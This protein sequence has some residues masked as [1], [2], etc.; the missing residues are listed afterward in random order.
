[1]RKFALP[2][3]AGMLVLGFTLVLAGFLAPPASGEDPADKGKAKSPQDVLKLSFKRPAVRATLAQ[4]IADLSKLAEVKIVVDWQGLIETGVKPE[5]A[6]TLPAAE[7]TGDKLLEQTLVA[8]ATKGNPLAWCMV[9]DSLCVTTQARVLRRDRLI[10]AAPGEAAATS[11]PAEAK[12][13]LRVAA[14]AVG[15]KFSFDK[16]PLGEVVAFLQSVSGVNFHANYTAMETSGVNKDTPVTME[17]SGISVA[18]ALDLITESL[19][20]GKGKLDSI[21]WIVEDGIVKITTGTSLDGKVQTRVYDVG[22]LLMSIPNFEGP[23]MNM[24]IATGNTTN[25][26]T[27]NGFYNTTNNG[28][29]AG[30]SSTSI[31][32][33]QQKVEMQ[34]K[35]SGIIQKSIGDDMWQPQGKGSIS[36]LRNMMVVS[37][38][39]LG[40]LLLE[41]SAVLK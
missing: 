21:Y 38:T 7:A 39:Q 28:T 15:R 2:L 33:D 8:V 13:P 17:V 40:F 16:T 1:M 30:G 41:K 31:T 19:S 26:S 23:R 3:C 22:D 36:F 5:A 37:Q 11:R 35:L 10:V 9:D 6:V 12:T 24:S 27:S 25:N 14:P 34:N 29:G 20:G 18:K 32:P 4:A